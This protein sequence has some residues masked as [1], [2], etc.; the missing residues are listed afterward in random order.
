[1][2]I[3]LII[4][5]LHFAVEPMDQV[6]V[7]GETAVF[8]CSVQS[9]TLVSFIWTF[10]MSRSHHTQVIANVTVP[11]I[12]NKYSVTNIG[13]TSSR[14]EVHRTLLSDAGSYTCRVSAGGQTI[15]TDANLEILS[16]SITSIQ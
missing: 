3:Q 8:H 4:D 12:S 15:Q 6:A 14:L 1:M 13:L 2:H 7:E 9:D 11:L 5:Q 16:K 10:T